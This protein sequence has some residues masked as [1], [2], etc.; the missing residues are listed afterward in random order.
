MLCYH[1]LFITV[2][3]QL[4]ENGLICITKHKYNIE[5]KHNNRICLKQSRLLPREHASLSK[6]IDKKSK[7]ERKSFLKYKQGKLSE[8]F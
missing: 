1:K 4:Q 3:D 6:T 7:V 2:I 8:P 5:T